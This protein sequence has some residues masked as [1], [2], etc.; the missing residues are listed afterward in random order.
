MKKPRQEDIPRTILK[1]PGMGR[2]DLS[3]LEGG[4]MLLLSPECIVVGI[5]DVPHLMFTTPEFTT[6]LLPPNVAE[7]IHEVKRIVLQSTFLT[8]PELKKSYP[9]PKW[10][11]GFKKVKHLKLADATLDNLSNL[12]DLPIK[13][14]L[15]CDTRF[16]DA[17]NLV[18]AIQQFKHLKYLAYDQSFPV[19]VVEAVQQ[20]NLGVTLLTE[21]DY[22]KKRLFEEE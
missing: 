15:I 10:L 14:L 16:S 2:I 22:N 20:L 18:A 21:E 8:K 1:G 6:E 5:G 12:K 4:K 9:L 11:T 17:D 19:N 7:G 3:G 13:H